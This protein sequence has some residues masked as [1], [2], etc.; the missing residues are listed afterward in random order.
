M[1][2]EHSIIVRR[3]PRI[4]MPHL[5]LG[6]AGA[7]VCCAS[8]V[9]APGCSS[10]AAGPAGTEPAKASV[11][12][13]LDAMKRGDEATAR[14]MLTR[15]ARAKTE[16]LGVPVAP[17]VNDT[18]TYTVRECE[19]VSD[20]NDLAHVATIWS[21]VDETGGKNS[22]TIIWAVRLDPEG[23]RVV[24]MAMKIFEDM[25]PLLLNFEDP[26]DMI[27]KQEMVAEEL[28]RRAAKANPQ[29]AE[30]RTARGPVP[31]PAR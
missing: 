22:E 17:P 29:A 24:G 18:A 28:S 25:P 11:V 4:R 30:P 31:A 2:R 1:R 13:F 27:A 26:Q 15:V 5:P 20:S 12:T 14:D 7:A 3:L 10:S 16:E 8:F 6:L 21:D 9:F 23:W 19:M